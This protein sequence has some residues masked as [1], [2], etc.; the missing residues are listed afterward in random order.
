VA[1]NDFLVSGG[2]GIFVPVTPPEGLDVSGKA[3]LFREQIATWLLEQGGT[4]D[5][6]DFHS[7]DE[8]VFI[9]P[10]KPPIS[11]QSAGQT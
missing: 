8:P 7:I 3:E 9:L 2:D 11:C 6:G 5:P 10:G 4:I 1:T